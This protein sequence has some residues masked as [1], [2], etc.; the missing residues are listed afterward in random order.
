VATTKKKKA[1]GRR[2][3][4][5]FV[6]VGRK[7]RDAALDAA[8]YR[9]RLLYDAWMRFSTEV[10]RVVSMHQQKLASADDVA[11]AREKAEAAWRP[12]KKA[13]AKTIPRTR[14]FAATSRYF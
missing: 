11:R 12:Y 7:S 6:V 10:D 8:N 9:I 5:P 14:S 4:S 1:L 3:Q 2:R 13:R